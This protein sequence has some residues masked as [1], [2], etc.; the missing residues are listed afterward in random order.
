MRATRSS[1]RRAAANP[2]PAAQ[3][4]P[5]EALSPRLRVDQLPVELLIELLRPLTTDDLA[6]VDQVSHAFHSA[7][8]T[9][10][11]ATER[12]QSVVEHALRRRA[13]E[14][15]HTLPETLG[16]EATWEQ[17]LLW[18][19]RR[20]RWG[21]QQVVECG[22]D[23][24]VFVDSGGGVLTSGS[25]HSFRGVL[26]HGALTGEHKV[27]ALPTVV[28]GLT[29]VRVVSV[30]AGSVYTIALT[31]AGQ[32]FSW[33]MGERGCLGHGNEQDLHT[34]KLVEAL[35]AMRVVGVAASV[36]YS[37]ARTD[38]GRLFQWG[39]LNDRAG[40]SQHQQLFVPTLVTALQA[41]KVVDMAAGGSFSLALNEA[42]RVYSW[43]YGGVCNALGHAWQ[44]GV[45]HVHDK[46]STPTMIAAL[47]PHKIVS[48]KSAGY[49]LAISEAGRVFSWGDS[50]RGQLGHGDE[51]TQLTPK[52]IEAL[53]DVKVVVV[54]AG[55]SHSIAVTDDGQIY[56]WG[57]GKKGEL[58]HGNMLDQ[59]TPKRI[60]ALQGLRVVGAKAGHQRSLAVTATGKVYSWGSNPQREL[61][62]L[63]L[64]REQLGFGK[65]LPGVSL[66]QLYPSLQL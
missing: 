23:F 51:E 2:P 29:G 64:E 4:R 45:P 3:P 18:Q 54:E 24:W 25:E 26:G 11:P 55:V 21:T 1:T 37:L 38:A 46:I 44:P 63:R 39:W 43:G 48:V 7:P 65:G 5:D 27:V 53:Q 10:Q 13:A 47:E 17:L 61:E 35:Q 50:F 28:A 42:G 15:G 36:D 40:A 59:F 12:Q 57:D 31:E 22:A 66:P 16:G 58:G 30:A 8:Q 14:G 33:G 52:L 56:S 32:V 6:R 9:A 62:L 41:T 20:R 49:G 19:E 60:E 34:P